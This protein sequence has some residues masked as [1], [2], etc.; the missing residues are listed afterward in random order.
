M[1]KMKMMRLSTFCEEYDM[2]RTTVTDLVHSSDFPAYKLGKCWYV[3]VPAFEKW[4]EE[5]H[6]RCYRYA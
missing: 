6:K 3:D 5:K 1:A 2:P 4:R